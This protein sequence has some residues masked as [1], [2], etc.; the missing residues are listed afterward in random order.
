MNTYGIVSF[1]LPQAVSYWE[2]DQVRSLG[3]E[4]R[5]NTRV[6]RDVSAE[7]LLERYDAV[8]L[9]IGM[10]KVPMLGIGGEELD[11]VYDAIDFVKR[12]K[13]QTS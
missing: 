13:K 5:T 4:I 10:G 3:V 1:R 6:G 7:E 2:V 9:A 8:V 11:G 12:T